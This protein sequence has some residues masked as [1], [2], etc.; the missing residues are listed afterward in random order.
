MIPAAPQMLL[1]LAGALGGRVLPALDPDA[2]AAGD[3]R[4]IALML[5]LLAQEADGAADR[6]VR[7]SAEMREI[8]GQEAI[9]PADYRVS[10]LKAEHDRLTALL[11]DLH[12][13]V[14]AGRDEESQ[15]INRRIWAH[16]RTSAESRA[17]VLPE[18]A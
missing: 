18:S 6:L 11:I 7:E 5:V 4:T 12:A 9:T 1:T 2:Y 14:E 17:L 13:N 10:A 3:T 16:L 15:A 8:L